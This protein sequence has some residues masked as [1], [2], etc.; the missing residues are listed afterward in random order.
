MDVPKCNH[1]VELSSDRHKGNAGCLIVNNNHEI[2][3]VKNFQTKEYSIP[4]G[5]KKKRRNCCMHGS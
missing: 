2:L 3:L 5:S 1:S 4:G